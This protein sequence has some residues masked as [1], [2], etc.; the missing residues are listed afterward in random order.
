MFRDS[1]ANA[2]VPYLS[3]SFDQILYVWERDMN[4]RIVERNEPDV[5]IQQIVERFLGTRQRGISEFE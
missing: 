3:E 1:F 2:L 5:V 4:P